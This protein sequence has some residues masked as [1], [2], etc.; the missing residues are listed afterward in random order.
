MA[1]PEVSALS[2]NSLKVT[3]SSVEGDGVTARGKVTEF[4]V[5]LLT[6]QTNNPYAPPVVN[7]VR[8]IYSNALLHTFYMSR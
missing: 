6:E 5:N 2:S 1:P 3:W 8:H 4:R 7:Q